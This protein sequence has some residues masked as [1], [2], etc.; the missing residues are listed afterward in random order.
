MTSNVGR[1]AEVRHALLPLDE[2]AKI[3][4]DMGIGHFLIDEL[5]RRAR[6]NRLKNYINDGD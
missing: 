3:L 1:I 5:I 6:Q 2:V 4:R